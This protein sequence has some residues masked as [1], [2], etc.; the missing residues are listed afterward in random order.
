MNFA[1][2]L[3]FNSGKARRFY[4]LLMC[5]LSLRDQKV[6]KRLMNDMLGRDVIRKSTNVPKFSSFVDLTSYYMW[7]CFI[8]GF[9][10][11]KDQEQ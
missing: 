5:F 2:T 10:T 11:I 9:A 1:R 6:D 8:K 7:M 3:Y 4:I